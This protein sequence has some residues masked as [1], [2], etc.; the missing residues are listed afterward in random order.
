MEGRN[1]TILS[2]ALKAVRHCLRLG[3]PTKFHDGL[4]SWRKTQM[5]YR[6]EK[7]PFNCSHRE[8]LLSELK[9]PIKSVLG[10]I[11]AHFLPQLE[12]FVTLFEI[13]G[14]TPILQST[15][16]SVWQEAEGSLR[17]GSLQLCTFPLF[18]FCVENIGAMQRIYPDLY[19]DFCQ[20]AQKCCKTARKRCK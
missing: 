9:G 11:E 18:F 1:S 7:V 3:C 20:I 17:W 8:K 5:F 12:R 4:V 19:F 6:K 13:N 16:A 15:S 14:N 10:A 2:P